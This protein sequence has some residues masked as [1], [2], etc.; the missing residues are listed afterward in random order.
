MK[1]EY[2]PKECSLKEELALGL[3]KWGSG[4]LRDFD[5][6]RIMKLNHHTS[7]E[8]ESPHL[9]LRGFNHNSIILRTSADKS[10]SLPN[11]D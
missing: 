9:Q 3:F 10:N 2:H 6:T 5:C 11:T 1:N 4:V 8:K 7:E